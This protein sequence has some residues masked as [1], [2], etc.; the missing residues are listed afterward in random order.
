MLPRRRADCGVEE[1]TMARATKPNTANRGAA[2]ATEPDEADAEAIDDGKVID[3]I[4]GLPMPETDKERVRQRTAR[5][6]SP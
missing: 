1:S 5:A 3:Y 4:T 6:L 2:E